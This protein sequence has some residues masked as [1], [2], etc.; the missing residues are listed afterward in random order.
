MTRFLLPLLSM[1]ATVVLG[2]LLIHR[3]VAWGFID[4][5]G[6]RKVHAVPTPRT[7]GLAM[8]PQRAV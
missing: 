1:T 5:P 3:A 6:E 8:A 7:G 4:L 2:L